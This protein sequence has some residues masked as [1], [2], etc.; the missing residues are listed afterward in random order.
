VVAAPSICGKGV[1]K[2]AVSICG[3]GWKYYSRMVRLI[4]S[5]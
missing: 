2:K 4:Q 5:L 1:I 3:P